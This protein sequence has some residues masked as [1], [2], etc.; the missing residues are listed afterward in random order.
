LDGEGLADF[1]IV[2]DNGDL[3]ETNKALAHTSMRVTKPHRKRMSNALPM[4]Y[5][6]EPERMQPFRNIPKVA[7]ALRTDQNV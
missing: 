4:P 1:R 6:I 5:I 3:S 7:I 2:S